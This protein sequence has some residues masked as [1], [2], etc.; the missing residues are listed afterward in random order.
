M[1]CSI[2]AVPYTSNKFVKMSN[3]LC[4]IYIKWIRNLMCMKLYRPN[5]TCNKSILKLSVVYVSYYS[6]SAPCLSYPNP[7]FFIHAKCHRSNYFPRKNIKQELSLPVHQMKSVVLGIRNHKVTPTVRTN[8]SKFK[9]G[10]ATWTK[11][12]GIL[13]PFLSILFD[14]DDTTFISFRNSYIAIFVFTYE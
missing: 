11:V 12:T 13:E 14:G 3:V 1:H 6:D 4:K 5:Q 7:V 2:L 10:I 9:F 8:A